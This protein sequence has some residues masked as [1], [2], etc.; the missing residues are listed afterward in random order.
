[1]ARLLPCRLGT[2]LEA[3]FVR[4]MV[5][6]SSCADETPLEV[7]IVDWASAI[8]DDD[9]TD[10][11]GIDDNEEESEKVGKKEDADDDRDGAMACDCEL[12]EM[13]V[14]SEGLEV[15]LIPPYNDE[16]DKA[17]ALLDAVP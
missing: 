9:G 3:G 7:A 6:E 5:E 14:D 10:V 4:E 2:S 12:V 16:E 13:V 15:G 11:G 8:K 1:M 17:V